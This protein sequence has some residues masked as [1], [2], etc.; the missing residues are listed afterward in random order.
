MLKLIYTETGF[1][2]ERLPQ[3]LEEWVL[4]RVTLS[5]RAGLRLLFEPSTASFLIAVDKPWQTLLQTA[6]DLDNEAI[7]VCVCDAECVEVSLR[8]TWLTTDGE[9]AE[10][11]F[12]A[13]ISDRT[14]L[15]LFN[16][17][18]EAQAIKQRRGWDLNPR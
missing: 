14:E 13:V 1:W 17:W 4:S 12:V 3:S 2:L 11:V 9:S 16:L 18:L 5:L 7:A 8:G 6:A 15:L 10:G